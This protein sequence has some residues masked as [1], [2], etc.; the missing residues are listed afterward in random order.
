M[1]ATASAMTPAV[2]S[3]DEGWR[4]RQCNCGERRER[5]SSSFE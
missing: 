1:G 5:E 4:G 2:L 3:K